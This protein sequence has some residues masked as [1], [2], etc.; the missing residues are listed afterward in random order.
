MRKGLVLGHVIT[1]HIEQ[2]F[3][4]HHDQGVDIGLQLGQAVVGVG[5]ATTAF[6][7]EWL[8]D[9]ADGQ[10]AHLACDAGNHRCGASAGASSHTR[11][12][13]QHV[14]AFDGGANIVDRHFSRFTT[15][16]RLAAGTQTT[17]AELNAFVRVAANQGL[18]VRVGTDEFHAL[19][20]TTNHVAHCVAATAANADDF[21]LCAEVKG[22]FFN[23]FDRHSCSP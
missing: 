18:R 4:Q 12:D 2:L 15:F 23:H 17:G 21:D 14:R 8:G 10:N 1:Q 19:H 13:E 7:L 3:V 5:H 20:T 6:K 9:H 16:V 11:R 22:F